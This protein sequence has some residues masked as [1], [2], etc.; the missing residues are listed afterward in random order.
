ML[1]EF[2]LDMLL[3]FIFNIFESSAM[4]VIEV[5]AISDEVMSNIYEYLDFFQYAK[6][7]I[8]FFIP[9]KAFAFGFKWVLLLFAVE[10]LWPKITW[11]LKK[12]PFLGIS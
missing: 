4:D 11:L 9:P 8:A 2:L 1:I 6:N 7:I 12:I 3:N 5:P 10:K